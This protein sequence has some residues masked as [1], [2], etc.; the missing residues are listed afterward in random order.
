MTLDAAIV[1]VDRAVAH[2]Q[3]CQAAARSEAGLAQ[4]E[5]SILRE[6]DVVLRAI[7]QQKTDEAFREVEELLLRGLQTVFGPEWTKVRIN[8][9]QKAGRLWGE[10]TLSQGEH[11][12][13]PLE[14]FGGGPTSLV[15]FLL[16]LLVVRR[17]GLAPVLLL[18]ETFSQVSASALPELA[19]FLRMLVDKL[20][21]VILLVTHQPLFAESAT[22]V[23]RASYENGR[24]VFREGA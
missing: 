8:C 3:R 12:G 15:S 16:R 1:E 20:G 10:L 11:E 7:L 4:H 21:V 14:A 13:P 19:K 2:L 17:T 9:S 18:D 24:T 6:A 23:Y 5:E 22:R